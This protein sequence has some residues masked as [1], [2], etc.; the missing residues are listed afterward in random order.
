MIESRSF[1]VT[2]PKKEFVQEWYG[3]TI[4][5]SGMCRRMFW[6]NLVVFVF[7]LFYKRIGHRIIIINDQIMLYR[8][9]T[10]IGTNHWKLQR[11]EQIV[12]II[13]KKL[14]QLVWLDPKLTSIQ[15][16]AG[17]SQCNFVTKPTRKVHIQESLRHTSIAQSCV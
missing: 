1:R 17:C 2:R 15:W 6:S 16:T 5:E 12:V 7:N 14:N 10:G 4:R 9:D 3:G 11:N 13:E 8:P